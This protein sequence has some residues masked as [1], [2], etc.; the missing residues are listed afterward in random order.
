MQPCR[1]S[2]AI[3]NKPLNKRPPRVHF[4]AGYKAKATCKATYMGRSLGESS[5]RKSC[6]CSGASNT[7]ILKTG[8]AAKPGEDLQDLQIHKVLARIY[9]FLRIY[10]L[11]KDWRAAYSKLHS[12]PSH[13]NRCQGGL[14]LSASARALER[15]ACNCAVSRG[16]PW[17]AVRQCC[18]WR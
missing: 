11:T 12:K 8:R 1:R 15:R 9:R 3:V 2:K 6:G 18:A 14:R 5:A 13:S 16:W 17:R 4:L 10:R 7:A